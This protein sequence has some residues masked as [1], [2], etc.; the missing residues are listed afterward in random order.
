MGLPKVCATCRGIVIGL[1]RV[2]LGERDVEVAGG[3]V[4]SDAA[5]AV[6][7][8]VADAVDE[9][10]ADALDAVATSAVAAAAVGC[11]SDSRRTRINGGG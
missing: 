6:D 4:A 7:A 5:G 11:G 2:H 1:F 3:L 10:A 9:F 8:V